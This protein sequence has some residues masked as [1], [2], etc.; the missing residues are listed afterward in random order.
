MLSEDR[1]QI[2]KLARSMLGTRWRHQGRDPVH[3]IDCGGV[4]VWVGW[5]RGYIPREWDV[6]RY[7]RAPDGRSLAQ[8]LSVYAIPKDW[9]DWKP[10]DIVLLRQLRG[11]WPTHMGILTDHGGTPYMIHSLVTHPAR[12]V[13][14][15]VFAGFWRSAMVG[16]YMYKGVPD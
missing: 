10:G 9:A 8:A 5:E 7:G 2:V 1:Q 6:T 3:G 11:N 13:V 12:R 14:E 4:I 16:V 15:T